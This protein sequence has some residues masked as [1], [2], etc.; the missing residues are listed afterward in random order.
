MNMI[1][2]IFGI[3]NGDICYDIETYPNVFTFFAIHSKTK[4]EWLFEISDRK[5]E[6]KLF[7]NFLSTMSKMACRLVGFNNIG[8]DYPVIHFIYKNFN[9]I[10][11]KDIYDKAMSIINS[12]GQNL[13]HMI[14]ENERIVPQ[15]DLYKIHHFDNKSKATSL[16]VLEFNMRSESIETLPFKPGSILTFKQIDKLIKYNRYDVVQTLKFYHLSSKQIQ[17]RENLSTK[18]NKNFINHNDVRIGKDYIIMQLEKNYPGTCYEYKNGK[19]EIRQTIRLQINLKEVILPYIK[20]EHQ[21]FNK[22]LEIFK[23]KILRETKGV[24]EKLNSLKC[25]IQN[26]TFHFGTGGIH[27]SVKN[28]KFFSNDEYIIEDWD[29]ASYY[30]NLAIANRFYPEHLGEKF[31]NIYGNIYK[32]RKSYK[33]GT[34]EN[35]ILKLALNGVYGDSNSPYSPFFDA[36]Y[37]MSITING[38]L[39]LCMMVDQLLKHKDVKL[40]QTNTD[41]L[42][43]LYPRNIKNWVHAV[44]KWWENLTKLELESNEYRKMFIRDVNNYIAEDTNGKIKRKGQ[45]DYELEWHKDHSAL[46]IPMAV[47]AH[48]IKGRNINNFIKL[49]KNDMDFM[50]RTKLPKGHILKYGGEQI[51]NVSRYYISTDGYTLEKVMPPH[52]IVGKYKR[53][54]S[55][56]DSFY[57]KISE[58][59]G[60]NWDE[61]IHTKNKSKYEKRKH[62]IHPG[63]GVKVCNNLEGVTFDDLNYDY[64]IQKAIELVEEAGGPVR[65]A[66][67]WI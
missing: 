53:K 15:I 14:W 29:V 34:I 48:F 1:D 61:R 55:I 41:G 63:W 60:D 47:S 45:Y 26:F 51:Q 44:M 13:Q 23:N 17:F 20:F 33:K 67:G 52:G 22:I 65:E 31:C 16:K 9:F 18:Y 35:A 37:T 58:E 56:T 21:E 28:Q 54:N 30:P 5:N 50:F 7:R 2:F 43:I 42:T 24:F 64:Y 40:L 25:Q 27:G 8:F 39:L 46:I 38:Q 11:V 59:V 62:G 66:F 10:T 19:R 6:I 12:H 57:E 32:Q 4:Q 3:S 36:K 49:H